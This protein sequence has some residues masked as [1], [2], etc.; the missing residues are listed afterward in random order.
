MKTLSFV[1]PVYNE[2]Q[3]LGKTFKALKD[4]VTPNGLKLSEVIFVDDG[5]VDRT[6]AIIKANQKAIEKTLEAK[7]RIVS[8]GKNRGKGYA[9]KQGM[10]ASDASYTLFFDAD[11]STPLTELSKFM[12]FVVKDADVIIGTRKNG[13]STVLEHQP[14]LRESLGKAFTLITKTFL[15]LKVTDFTCG[16]KMFSKEAKNKV[17]AKSAIETWGYDAEILYLANKFKYPIFEKAVTWSNDKNTKV[18]LYKAIPQTF[19]ELFLIYWNHEIKPTLLFMNK[20]LNIIN[21]Y[22]VFVSKNGI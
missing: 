7:I 17:F 16:F 3:R 19:Y 13:K 12:P 21:R 1:I 20:N 18:K 15:R 9:V 4:F 6:K 2:E 22:G 8:Y 10:L 14:K 11:I 5:S